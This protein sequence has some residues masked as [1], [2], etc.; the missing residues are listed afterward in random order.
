MPSAH[1][2]LVL[3]KRHLR[4]SPT[5]KSNLKASQRRFRMDCDCPVWMVGRTPT[6]DVVPRQSTG[7]S[8]LRRAE[9]VRDSILRQT[10]SDPVHGVTIAECVTKSLA[11][12]K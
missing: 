4:S 5:S 12:K 2:G 11:S 3:F 9:A 8:D 7:E 10:K 1:R 6:G